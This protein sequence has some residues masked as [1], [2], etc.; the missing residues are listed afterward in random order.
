MLDRPGQWEIRAI[1][2]RAADHLELSQQITLN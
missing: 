1:A 2:R